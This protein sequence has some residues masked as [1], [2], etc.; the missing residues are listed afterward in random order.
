V[1]DPTKA[2]TLLSRIGV[3]GVD[4]DP[5]NPLARAS[6]RL[7][8]EGLRSV[9]AIPAVLVDAP[10]DAP[11]WLGF[12]VLTE[13]GRI[14]FF[15]GI[16]HRYERMQGGLWDGRG[17]FERELD[18]DHLTLEADQ[19]TWH[20]TDRAG[21][22]RQGGGRTRDVG[23]SRVLWV[24]VTASGVSDFRPLKASTI[25]RFEPVSNVKER[26]ARIDQFLACV[27]NGASS[28]ILLQTRPP[29]DFV[30]HVGVTVAPTGAAP[31]NG[32]GM[33]FPYAAPGIERLRP[34]AGTIASHGALLL[35]S[36][37]EIQV[38][39]AWLPGRG[40]PGVLTF[41]Y[42]WRA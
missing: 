8:D 25:V 37:I 27:S 14:L 28:P 30:L 13:S 9:S 3:P 10:S 38:L 20:M 26:Q 42:A 5:A 22:E 35:S 19:R 40:T 39:A 24:C 36:E 23:A 21:Q 17:R 32:D 7:L 6:R 4:D 16:T 41:S 33:P 1:D 31:Y 2:F 18:V 34:P 15:P 29:G 11:V 12:F